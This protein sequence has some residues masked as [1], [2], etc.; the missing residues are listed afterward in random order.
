[1]AMQFIWGLWLIYALVLLG[2][3]CLT[4]NEQ[5]RNDVPWKTALFGVIGCFLWPFVVLALLVT[6]MLQRLRILRN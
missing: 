4:R 1:M 2:A 3:L 6:Q 5:L